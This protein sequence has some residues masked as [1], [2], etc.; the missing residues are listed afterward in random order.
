MNVGKSFNAM[1]IAQTVELILEDFKHFKLDDFKLCFNNAKKGYYGK[2]YDRLDGQIVFEWLTKYAND[3]S[4]EAQSFNDKKHDVYKLEK[5]KPVEI[6]PEGQKK[7]IEILKDA[8]KNVPP[9][10]KVEKTPR[11]KTETE[12]QIQI[13]LKEFETIFFKEGFEQA[14]QRFIKFEDKT[15]SQ[16]EYVELKLKTK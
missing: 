11:E 3:R 10:V 4:N 15:L 14:G 8:I 2:V 12:K 1:Q 13:Y 9:E 5:F 7:V 6:N 16:I